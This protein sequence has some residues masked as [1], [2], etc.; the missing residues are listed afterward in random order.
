MCK[1]Y[2]IGIIIVVA[3]IIAVITTFIITI[4][5]TIIFRDI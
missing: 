5:V 3:F 4:A 1:D 2:N